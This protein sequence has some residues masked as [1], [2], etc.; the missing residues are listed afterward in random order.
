MSI[1]F[2]CKCGKRFK[3]RDELAGKKG[4]CDGC[5]GVVLIP[6]LP[7]PEP[8]PEPVLEVAPEEVGGGTPSIYDVDDPVV[9]EPVWT[10]QR[11]EGPE[12]PGFCGYEPVRGTAVARAQV[13]AA[14]MLTEAGTRGVREWFYLLIGL[15]L[16]PL[17]VSTMYSGHESID[18]RIVDSIKSH[19][20][21]AQTLKDLDDAG[22]LTKTRLL[23]AFPGHRLEGAFLSGDSE[24]HW[25]FALLAAGVF[26]GVGVFM[27]PKSGCK[28][29]H[30]FFTGLF[31]GTA[32]VLL[33]LAVQFI[34]AHMRGRIYVPR[35]II[36]LFILL[37]K[38]IQMSYDL[39]N[40]PDSGFLPSAI[41]FTVG[42]GLCEELCKALPII[43]HYKT[44]GTMDWRGACVWGFLS[45]AGF[46]V[47]EAIMYSGDYY[48]GISDGETYLVRFVSCV[49]LHG[50]W[51][52]AAAIFISKH[53]VLIQDGEEWYSVFFG[54]A[55][56][57]S[58]PMVL[59]GLYDT[60][61]KKEMPGPAAG[62]G[63]DQFCVAGVS[64]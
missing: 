5:G 49:A 19:P 55:A 9:E 14:A 34:A 29:Q 56:L 47:A 28:P 40:D 36:G 35:G 54:A 23:M 43:W 61:L 1:E 44:K 21:V 41:R 4:K 64:D 30:A 50:I 42:V 26:F 11:G 31:T 59:H 38:G 57:V 15:A 62:G 25:L 2:S 3:V 46:G 37:L 58:V 32:G 45:G 12:D 63:G 16:F 18:D 27:L 6:K 51:A 7:E 13:A 17:L 48:N 53:P 39:A 8:E 60:M 20:E 33:L 22:K 10:V 52:A 24:G